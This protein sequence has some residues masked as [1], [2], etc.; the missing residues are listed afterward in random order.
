MKIDFQHFMFE[1]QMI[2]GI[3]DPSLRLNQYFLDEIMGKNLSSLKIIWLQIIKDYTL[4]HDI[5]LLG[6]NIRKVLVSASAQSM[7]TRR[8]KNYPI[9]FTV[10]F[11]ITED[12]SWMLCFPCH[13]VRK[14]SVKF[15]HG[16]ILPVTECELW[17][18]DKMVLKLLI[19]KL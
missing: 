10:A 17:F 6:L 3:F 1:E 7:K 11:M 19:T 18:E 15:T 13:N 8:K 2:L 16:S 9:N 5:T 14:G 12:M 4:F